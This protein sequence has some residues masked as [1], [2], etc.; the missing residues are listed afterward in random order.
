MPTSNPSR[1]KPTPAACGFFLLFFIMIASHCRAGDWKRASTL[2]GTH[3]ASAEELQT[4][5]AQF[6]RKDVAYNFDDAAAEVRIH[7]GDLVVS[8]HLENDSLLIV[9][10]DLTIEGNYRDSMSR[11]GVLVVLG[12]MRVENLYSWGAIYVRNDLN[13][14]G[15]VLTVYNDFTFEVDG[16][17][18]ARALVIDD[19]YSDYQAGKIDVMLDVNDFDAVQISLALKAFEPDFFTQ[20]DH[21]EVGADSTLMDL[22]FDAKM[23]AKR[24]ANDGKIFRAQP[25]AHTLIDDVEVVLSDATSAASLAA[26]ITRD[27]L[28]AQLIAGRAELPATLHQQ[29]LATNDP[30]VLEWLARRAP[31]LVVV[32]LAQQE[33]TPKLAEKL[34][35][36]SSLSAATVANMVTSTNAKVRAIVARYAALDA[37]SANRLA[38]DRDVNVRVAAISFQLY[39][40]NDET[41][42]TLVKDASPAVRREIGRAIAG[43]ASGGS[44]ILDSGIHQ[45]TGKDQMFKNGFE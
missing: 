28:L 35:D 33:I 43:Q 40:L 8:G 42:S 30:I 12:E 41:V 45:R 18:N 14:S 16:K 3:R 1:C 24:V 22:R 39:L 19:K 32:T 4:L 31:K 26:L 44:D 37:A 5:R 34:L 15:L 20:P 29:L 2:S 27:P 7:S 25:S 38:L 13:A 21:L 6:A 23:G 17:V 10:G 36:D 9:Q 11:F